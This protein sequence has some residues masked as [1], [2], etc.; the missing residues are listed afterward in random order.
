MTLVVYDQNGKVWN[1]ITGS[2]EVPA[3][4]PYLEIEVPAGKMVASVDTAVT[5]N[6]P[7]YADLP[8]PKVDLL[9]QRLLLAEGVINMMLDI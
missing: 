7:I 1:M 8:I 3:G 9:E 2:Y 6:I 4:I 5:P